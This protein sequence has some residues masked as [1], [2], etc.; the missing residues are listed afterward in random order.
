M[1][2]ITLTFNPD[3]PIAANINAFVD[4]LP[5][6]VKVSKSIKPARKRT[7]KKERF[8]ASLT[9][10]AKQAED[11]AS[12]PHKSYTSEELIASIFDD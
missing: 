5:S 9:K 7:T 3:M 4:S 6:G 1:E 11:L 2:T 10:A 8:L 12:K